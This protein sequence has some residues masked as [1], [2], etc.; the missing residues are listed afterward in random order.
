MPLFSCAM[1][2]DVAF[3]FSSFQTFT[4]KIPEDLDAAVKV[5]MRVKAPLGRRNLQ[6][7]I[8]ALRQQTTFKGTM[9][10]INSMVDDHPVLDE[11]LWKLINWVAEYYF[12]PLG[13]SAKVAL[14]QNLSAAY[15]PP[16]KL[17]VKSINRNFDL[18]KLH[19]QAPVQAR[20]MEYLNKESIFIKM[21][22]LEQITKGASSICR[23]LQ[24]KNLV[25]FKEESQ[26]PDLTGFS[27]KPIPKEI[28]FSN[29]QQQA[30]DT[31]SIALKKKIFK[32]FLIHGVTGSG[33]TEI[34]I[35]IARR[36]L[37]EGRSVI[38]LLPEIA[39][40]P[41]IAGRFRSVFGESVALWHSKMSPSARA[42]TWKR[43]CDGDFKVVIGAR[44]AIFTP[45][46]NLGLIVV[47]EEQEHSFK[48]ESPDPRYHA[49]EVALMRGKLHQ[50]AVI[51][52]SATPSLESYYNHLQGKFGYI[53]LPERFGEAEYPEV[54]T[55]DMLKESAET[56]EYGQVFSRLLLEKITNCLERKEQVILLQNR[57]GYAP[58]LRCRDCGELV[59]C[60][61]CQVTLT[62]HSAGKYLQCHFC[63]FTNHNILDQ[64]GKCGSF[65]MKLSGTGTQRVE[66]ILKEKFPDI[67][68]ARV[69]VDSV[70]SGQDISSTLQRFTDQ[71]ID[72]LLGTQMIAKGLD[73]ANVTLVG[74]IN[75][76]TGLYL[77]DFRAGERAF[78][79]IYQASGRAGRGKKPGQVV[80]Q[81]YNPHN[82]VIEC[83]TQLNLH[84]Y[85]KI[86][87]KERQE[88]NYPPYTWIVK[89]ELSGPDR[90]AL[91]KT[92][93]DL[94]SYLKK[95]YKGLEILGPAFCYREKLRNRYRMQIVLKSLKT[96]DPGGRL[97][98]NFIRNK[99]TENKK[100]ISKS[101]RLNIDINPISLL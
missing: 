76:D 7:I 37:L 65:N 51:M 21:S 54:H 46:K 57:R 71:K 69:D 82:V 9:R 50:A 8:V 55:I 24:E 12:T 4:Y 22:S 2:A 6:G 60:P 34:Y 29:Y 88:L 93:A 41:Q 14:P 11:E 96:V 72:V 64:C 73:F 70:R 92:A 45:V 62:Y 31:I 26:L 77:P 58:L 85:Y 20:I 17:L 66:E 47:D 84:K 1:Y 78:Q 35:E 80:V 43:I 87:L 79:L 99:V 90:A 44:S 101:I 15:S 91:E 59:M 23:K 75:A 81:T 32:P 49:R 38:L 63:G 19:R 100:F 95:P 56:S 3:P 16:V 68:L 83:A 89:L 13:Q 28:K 5:G 30:I 86:A 97:L 52:A 98:H 61:N 27:L 33:K 74:I 42:W 25:E 94:R 18:D 53:N 40:T 39:L 48:Q 10:S 67:R 36:T